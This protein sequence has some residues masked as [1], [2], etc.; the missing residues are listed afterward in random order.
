MTLTS[1]SFFDST[2]PAYRGSTRITIF[3]SRYQSGI[4]KDWEHTCDENEIAAVVNSTQAKALDRA[5]SRT[6]LYADYLQGARYIFDV[7]RGTT[8]T[9][10][11]GDTRVYGVSVDEMVIGQYEELE[12]HFAHKQ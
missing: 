4:W 8:Q 5:F 12:R 6:L 2:Q 9:P 10:T 7:A 1:G 3:A 11:E